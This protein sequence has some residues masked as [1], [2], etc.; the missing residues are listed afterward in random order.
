MHGFGESAPAGE[1]YRHFGITVEAI[2]AAVREAA[3]GK[4]ANAA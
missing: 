1:L 3:P 4:A 2:V